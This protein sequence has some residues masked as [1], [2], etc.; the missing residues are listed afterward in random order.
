VTVV[1][2]S[3]AFV[4]VHLLK[5]GGTSVECAFAP[6]ARWNDLIV[7]STAWGE[8]LQ[9]LYKR[10]YGLEK[11]SSAAQI[12]NVIG[13]DLWTRYWTVAMVRHPLRIFESY[14]SW[15]AEI[16]DS[17]IERHRLDHDRFAYLCH[18]DQLRKPF[19]RWQA[20]RAY[21]GSRCFA[22][23][24]EA[25]LKQPLLTT[26]MTRRLSQSGAM[27]VDDVYKLEEIDRLWEAFEARTGLTLERLN[28]NQSRKR[29]CEWDS[30]HIEQMYRV[31]EPD[32]VNF[33]YE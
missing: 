2:R 24:V 27:I 28:V 18:N 8:L 5:C 20:T 7:G 17:Y 30:R 12:K 23:F 9:P 16:V 15:I 11:H 25:A 1:C 21:A 14:Y 6:H 29:E 19:A 26:T 33:N 4:F 32:F 10:L 31:F 22:D 13:A 3:R